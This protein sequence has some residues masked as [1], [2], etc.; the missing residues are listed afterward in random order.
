MIHNTQKRLLLASMLLTSSA[1]G[2]EWNI[3]QNTV[4]GSAPVMTQ[5]NSVDAKQ[6]VNGV[7]VDSA[8]DDVVN[9]AQNTLL[10]FSSITMTQSGNTGSSSVQAVN[11]MEGRSIQ[12]ALQ[13]TTGF[14]SVTMT[15]GSDLGGGN[16]QALNYAKADQSV[17]NLLQSAIGR[18]WSSSPES[19]GSVQAL[20]YAEADRYYGV[21][22]QAVG[23][24][25]LDAKLSVGEVR[26]NSIQ[27]DTG[28]AFLFQ[29]A[30][31][32]RVNMHGRGTLILNHIAP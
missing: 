17:E 19:A 32:K 20:N 9:S 13:T 14:G 5:S 26:V 27:G 7:S 12:N 22:A 28:S 6:A 24:W 1:H 2:A 10:G 30:L 8:N 16:T 31:I 4:L 25:R 15:Q 29:E 3:I 18:Q 23:I 21:I 11:L